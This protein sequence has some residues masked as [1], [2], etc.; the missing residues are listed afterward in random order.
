MD[1][2]RAGKLLTFPIP[3]KSGCGPVTWWQTHNVAYTQL[4]V[5]QWIWVGWHYISAFGV[6]YAVLSWLQ[7]ATVL[8]AASELKGF[9]GVMACGT[10][11]VLYFFLPHRMVHFHDPIPYSGF[12]PRVEETSQDKGIACRMDTLMEATAQFHNM[13]RI[14]ANQRPQGE[15]KLAGRFR[16]KSGMLP[17]WFETHNVP[18]TALTYRQWTWI[19][20]HYISAFGVMYAILSWLQDATVLDPATELKGYKGVIAASTGVLLYW[21]LPHRMYHFHDAQPGVRN[22]PEA[23]KQSAGATAAYPAGGAEAA[24]TAGP[25]GAGSSAV[26]LQARRKDKNDEVDV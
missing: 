23:L 21:L 22:E 24:P 20:W 8:R 10:G 15:Q 1:G 3:I 11:V 7:D 12:I 18:Y 16:E 9:K 19:M 6:M 5:R 13:D 25:S 17:D 2:K 26:E 4:T 14:M